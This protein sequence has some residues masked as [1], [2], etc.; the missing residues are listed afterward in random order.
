MI[1][2]I[3]TNNDRL[4]NPLLLCRCAHAPQWGVGPL[5][6]SN[7]PQ[8]GADFRNQLGSLVWE[9]CLLTQKMSF[10]QGV[11]PFAQ[12]HE[13]FAELLPSGAYQVRARVNRQ[14]RFAQCDSCSIKLLARVLQITPLTY[15]RFK[16][17][18]RN[19]LTKLQSS[20]GLSFCQ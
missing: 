18:A 2:T 10:A 19:G 1:A 6:A 7:F 20:G 4:T 9:S 5:L 14:I 11:V 15:S 3:E 13:G 8:Q 12:L 17:L 16:F